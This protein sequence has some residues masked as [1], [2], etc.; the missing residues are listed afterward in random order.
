[1]QL[2]NDKFDLD[3]FFARLSGSEPVLMIDYDGTLAP[4]VADDDEAVPYPGVRERLTQLLEQTPTRLVLVSERWSEDLIPLLGLP[5][6]P[7]IWGCQG[8]ERVYPDGTIKF[9]KLQPEAER[10]L[11]AARRWAIQAGLSDRLEHKPT[12]VVLNW[13]DLHPQKAESIRREVSDHWSEA[14][15][16]ADLVVRESN[17]Q[18][19]LRVAGID[20]GRAVRAIVKDGDSGAPSA[21]LG[22]DLSDEA[23]FRAMPADSLKV[24]VRREFCPTRAD[25]WLV[26]PVDL[27]AFLDRWLGSF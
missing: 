25:L 18:L 15:L 21:F 10:G 5:R 26:P 7:E 20:K 23:A 22:D 24:L 8:A 3:R 27:L 4:P 14:A 13:R 16:G 6:L 12:S 19:E 9:V 2:L 17:G 1:M 11:E